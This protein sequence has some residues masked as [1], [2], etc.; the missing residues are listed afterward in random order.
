MVLSDDDLD[1]VDYSFSPSP[2]PTPGRVTVMSSVARP[3]RSPLWVRRCRLICRHLQWRCRGP[4]TPPPLSRKWRCAGLAAGGPRGG[5]ANIA[6]RLPAPAQH[7]WGR[8]ISPELAARL[9]PIPA[10]QAANPLHRP[11]VDTD[12]F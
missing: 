11:R 9:G 8:R 6:S 5:F 7:A 2:S 1:Q 12:G 10:P 3:N 4:R